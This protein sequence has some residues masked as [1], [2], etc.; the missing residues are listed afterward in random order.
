MINMM[1]CMPY[2]AG[3]AMVGTTKGVLY[4]HTARDPT[5]V[6]QHQAHPTTITAL[7]SAQHSKMG[8]QAVPASQT[9]PATANNVMGTEQHIMHW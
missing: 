2:A 6:G 9:K 3:F 5:Q 1:A 7:V 4:A 8:K